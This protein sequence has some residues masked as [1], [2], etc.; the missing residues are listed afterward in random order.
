MARGINDNWKQPLGY[1]FINSTCKSDDLKTLVFQC[2]MKL[3]EAG[4]EV[5]GIISDM[6]SNFIHLSKILGVTTEKTYFMVSLIL[7]IFQY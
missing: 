5:K 4:A 7:N 3:K 2:V 6:G 1:F